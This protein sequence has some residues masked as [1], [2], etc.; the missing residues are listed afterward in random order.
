MRVGGDAEEPAGLDPEAL[1]LPGPSRRIRVEPVRLPEPVRTPE[2]APER[3]PGPAPEQDPLPT[4]D[5]PNK[6]ERQPA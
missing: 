3:R 4:P 6:P 2:R 1:D 5:A